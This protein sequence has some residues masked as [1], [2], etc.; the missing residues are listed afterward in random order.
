M[1]KVLLL[2]KKD[3]NTSALSKLVKRLRSLGYTFE[4]ISSDTEIDSKSLQS[5]NVCIVAIHSEVCDEEF[6]N[7]A[8]KLKKQHAQ[9]SVVGIFFGKLQF[10]SKMLYKYGFDVLFQHPL[11]EELLV[12]LLIEKEPVDLENHLLDFNV[13]NRV[14]VMEITAE[15]SMPFSLYLYLPANEKIIPYNHKDVPMASEMLTKFQDNPHYSLYIKKNELPNYYSY[16]ASKITESSIKLSKVEYK[17]EMQKQLK[18]LFAGFFDS[19]NQLDEKESVELIDNLNKMIEHVEDSDKD[20][21]KVL[22]ELS[23]TVSQQYSS[24]SHISNVGTYTAVFGMILGLKEVKSLK[25]G[26]MLHDVGMIDLPLELLIKAIEEMS[27]EEL[28][29]YQTHPDL[30][31]KGLAEK[32]LSLPKEVEEIISQHHE[33]PNGQ[34]FPKGLA[35]HEISE[36]AKVCAFADVFDKLTSVREGH[37]QLSP[38]QALKRISGLDG[39]DPEPVFDFEFH[40][41]ILQFFLGE[42]PKENWLKRKHE[43]FVQSEAGKQKSEEASEEGGS[44]SKSYKETDEETKK[45]SYVMSERESKEIT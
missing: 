3:Q 17:L 19:S 33:L 4:T 45:S 21:N 39:D 27:P 31:V 11:E 7:I 1:K 22:D 26:G 34:G 43:K 2:T 29:Q 35:S 32:G 12:N 42:D 38:V 30:G 13:M 9:M 40:S 15:E 5:F 10:D 28:E 41:E 8:L 23:K 44:R 24:Y 14:S 36:Y 20:R 6:L 16:F 18:S 25:V 37:L